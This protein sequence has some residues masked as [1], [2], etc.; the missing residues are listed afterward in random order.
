MILRYK[1]K[2]KELDNNQKLEISNFSKIMKGIS[3]PNSRITN[4][5]KSASNIHNLNNNMSNFNR[6]NAA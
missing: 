1:N 6:N 4:I 2:L 5:M 3:R